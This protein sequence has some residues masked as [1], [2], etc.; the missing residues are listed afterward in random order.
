MKTIVDTLFQSIIRL[1]DLIILN[2]FM[3]TVFALV[4]LQIYQ[5][6]FRRKCVLMPPSNI[7]DS[8]YFE[9]INNKSNQISHFFNLF[10]VTYLAIIYRKLDY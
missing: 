10:T 3:T 9:F 8:E 1:R 6:V 5:G 2:F 4:S 7:S